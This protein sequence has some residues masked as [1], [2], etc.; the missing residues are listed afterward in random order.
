M[1][2]L[3]PE[4]WPTFSRKLVNIVQH[5]KINITIPVELLST[6]FNELKA[7]MN[8]LYNVMSIINTKH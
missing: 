6:S 5:Y 2:N 3:S 1:T 4:N 7:T 8:K